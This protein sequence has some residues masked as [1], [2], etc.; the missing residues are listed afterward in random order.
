[1]RMRTRHLY[2]FTKLYT[3][4]YQNEEDRYLEQVVQQWKHYNPGTGGRE[5]GVDIYTQ[6]RTQRKVAIDVREDG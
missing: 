6:W 2:E 5:T 3:Q 1:M 4:L